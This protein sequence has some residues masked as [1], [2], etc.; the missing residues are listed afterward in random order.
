MSFETENSLNPA[1]CYLS[2]R[3]W[4]VVDYVPDAGKLCAEMDELASESKCEAA[5]LTDE[6]TH[7]WLQSVWDDAEAKSKAAITLASESQKEAAETDDEKPDRQAENRK[8]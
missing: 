8:S 3:C 4:P 7:E 5:G 1:E 2:G 6:E